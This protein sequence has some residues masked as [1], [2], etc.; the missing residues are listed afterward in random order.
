MRPALFVV[1]DES[2]VS[3]AS[4]EIQ[5]SS[6]FSF[7]FRSWRRRLF[8]ARVV[9]LYGAL[10]CACQF[11]LLLFEKKIGFGGAECSETKL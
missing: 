6:G 10:F 9:E 1:V 8:P 4:D 3:L 11:S 7:S 5:L 2:V